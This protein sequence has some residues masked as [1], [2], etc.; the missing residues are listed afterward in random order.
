MLGA[1]S[2]IVL[3][4]GDD[5]AAGAAA[6]ELVAVA[7]ECGSSYLTAAACHARGAVLVA[8]GEVRQALLL[9]RQAGH[10][11]S[12]LGTPYEGARTRMLLAEACRGLGDRETAEL[13]LDAARTT[14]SELGARPDAAQVEHAR[15]PAPTPA[16]GALS[17][18][19]VEVLVRISR[20]STNRAI[21]REL[22]ISERTVAS[23]ISHIFTKLGLA[24]RAAATAYVYE[25]GLLDQGGD[26]VHR[27]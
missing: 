14:F 20:G 13:E 8:A 22:V 11:W 24:S 27:R 9:L 17:A 19:E 7:Q 1:F 23:H 3:A 26:A 10:L 2:E 15:N 16:P 6:D 18:R 21:A 4:A 25:H 5:V 12:N